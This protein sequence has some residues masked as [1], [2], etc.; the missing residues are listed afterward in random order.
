ML[1]MIE[2]FT[3][4]SGS[5]YEVKDGYMR[6]VSEEAMRRD[7]EWL[8]VLSVSE[9]RLGYPVSFVLEPLGEGDVTIRTTT[10]VT[11]YEIEYA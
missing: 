8:K 6:R 9:I 1:L 5:T 7:G 10:Q 11:E 3:T 2:R 4:E